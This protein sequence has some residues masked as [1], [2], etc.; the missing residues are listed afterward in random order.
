LR[1]P[2]GK[3]EL[4]GGWGYLIGDGGSGYAIGQAALRL[5]ANYHDSRAAEVSFARKLLDRLGLQDASELR[6]KLYRA[7]DPRA[8]VARL[9]P[10]VI[11]A[12]NAGD[13]HANVIV[14][15]AA[16]ELGQLVFD[17]TERMGSDRRPL[18]RLAG[19]LL[20]DSTA[21]RARVIEDLT[22]NGGWD[23]TLIEDAPEAALACARMAAA[24]L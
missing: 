7:E 4:L 1:Y 24:M 5:L 3:S 6:T 21:Y 22:T 8:W 9:A 11:E 23:D 17:A 10:T 20:T 13:G 18:I 12:A 2:D 19:A 14:T 15:Y 16:G